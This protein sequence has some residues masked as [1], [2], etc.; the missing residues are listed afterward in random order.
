MEEKS[1]IRKISERTARGQAALE[2]VCWTGLRKPSPSGSN[3]AR[4]LPL[5]ANEEADFLNILKHMYIL[6]Y[7]KAATRVEPR[8]DDTSLAIKI[9]RDFL[10]VEILIS[11]TFVC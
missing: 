10:Y 2:A 6:A 4:Q 1:R 7:G 9:A 11:V 8:I 3:T 5:R